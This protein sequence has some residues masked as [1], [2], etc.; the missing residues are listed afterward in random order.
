MVDKNKKNIQFNEKFMWGVNGFSHFT[1]MAREK[2]NEG[3][4]V[5]VEGPRKILS[6]AAG[7]KEKKFDGIRNGIR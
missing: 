1:E 2:R 5:F 4:K 3:E 7:K 6:E